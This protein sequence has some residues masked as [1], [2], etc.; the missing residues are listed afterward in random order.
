MAY[1]TAYTTVQAVV[2]SV[3]FDA[4]TDHSR[5]C[6]TALR[7]LTPIDNASLVWPRDALSLTISVHCFTREPSIISILNRIKA[8]QRDH[9]FVKL[10]CQRSC[11]DISFQVSLS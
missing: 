9:I 10:K 1:T 4:L 6:E 8:C 5:Q 11:I 3:C 2:T 7:P